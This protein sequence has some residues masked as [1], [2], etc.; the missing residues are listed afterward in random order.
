MSRIL[1]LA[2]ASVA[3]AG[4]YG[5]VAIPAWALVAVL[6]AA[7][8]FA[9][10][11]ARHAAALGL[12]LLAGAAAAT[13]TVEFP[14]LAGL[15]FLAWGIGAADTGA[16]RGLPIASWM[17]GVALL[18]ASV[19]CLTWIPL[20]DGLLQSGSNLPMILALAAIG[21]ALAAAALRESNESHDA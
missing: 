11:H 10:W 14:G 13:K 18:A 16:P 4:L 7:S 5:V 9:R 21:V 19:A 17:S 3:C 20:R 8:S 12:L 6:A 2:G 15:G 1:T